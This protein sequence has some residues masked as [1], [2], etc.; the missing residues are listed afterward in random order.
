MRT[1]IGFWIALFATLSATAALAAPYLAMFGSDAENRVYHFY[2]DESAGETNLVTFEFSPNDGTITTAEIFTTL[3]RRD[4][5]TLY[6]ADP[7]SVVAG[8]TNGY[9][10][11]YAMSDAGSGKWALT[12]PIRKCGSYDIR[13]RYKVS[14]D[15]NWRW[16]TG[17]NPVVNISDV[18]TR[19]MIVYEM[20]ANVVDATGDSYASRSTFASLTNTTKN[21]NIDYISSLGVNTIW[22]QPFHP[23]GAKSDC[24]SGD[25]GSPYSIK[26]LFQVAEHLGSDGT[27]ATA[28][29]EFTNFVIAAHAKGVKVICDVIFNHVATDIEIE[30]DPDNPASLYST[31]SAEMRNVKYAWFSR[32]TGS[33]SDCAT[34]KPES[35][36]ANYHYTEPANNSS[37]IGPAP[38]DRNDFVWPDAYDLFWGTYSA[39]GNI[40]DTSDGAWTASTDV[41]KMTEYY[42]YFIRY[43]IEKTGGTMG[44]FRCDFA[45]GLPRQAWQYLINKAKSI[46]PE[47]YFVSESLDGGNIAYRA[48]KGGFDALNENELWAIVEDTDITTT[49]LRNII[50][51]R[52]TQFGL[53]LILRGTMNHDQGPWLGRKWDAVAMHSVFCAVDGTPQMYE[54]QELGYDALGQFSRERV[55]FGRTIPDIR[56]YHSMNNLWNNRSSGDNPALWHRYKD[57]NLGRSRATALR[58][59]NQYYLDRTGGQGPHSKIFSVMKYT[60]YGWDPKDQDVVLAFVNLQPGTANSGTFNVNVAPIYLNPT[61]TYNVRN[62]ASTSPG[63]YLWAQGR[64]GSDIAANGIYVGFSADKGQEGSIAQFLKLEEQGGSTPTNLAW[65]GNTYH[66]PTNGAITAADDLWVNI[67]SYP[68]GAASGGSVAYSVDNVTWLSATLS[69]DGKTASN[70]KWHANLGKFAAGAVVRYAVQ[71]VQQGGTNFWDNRGGS[72]Y[73][74]TVN[75]GGNGQRLQWIGVVSHWPT[76]GA[77]TASDDFW[78]DIQAWPTGAAANGFVVYSSDN[79]ATWPTR[80]LSL[81]NTSPSNDFWHA[82]LGKFAPGAT[83]QFAVSLSDRTGTNQLW[84]NNAGSNY[85]AYVNGVSTSGPSVYWA[86]NTISRGITRPD[87]S[88]LATLSGAMDL[89]VGSA[90]VGSTYELYRSTNLSSWVLVTNIVATGSDIAL[91]NQPVVEERVF[92]RI[93]GFVPY[94]ASV[95]EGDE[96]IIRAESWPAG[97]AVA[98]NIVYSSNGQNWLGTNMTKVG[99]SLNNDVWEVNLGYFPKGISIQYAIEIVDDQGFSRWDNNNSQNHSVAIRDPDQP[100]VT[101]P[102]LSY[103]PSNTTTAASSLDVTLTATDDFDAHPW[104][105]YTLDGSTPVWGSTLYSVPIHVTNNLTIKAIAFDQSGNTSGVVSVDVKVNEVVVMGSFKPYSVNPTFGHAVANGGITIDGSP[106]DWTTNMLVAL[107]VADDDPRTLGSNWTTHEAPIDFAYLW[108]AWDDNY[109]YLAW[110]YV[111]LTDLIDTA[112]AGSAGGGKISSNDGILQWIAID[113]IQGAGAAKDVWSKNGG[114]PYWAGADLPDYQVYMAGSLWQGYISRAVNGVFALD[115]GGVNYKTAAAAGISYA[116]GNTLGSGTLWMPSAN[117]ANGRYGTLSAVTHDTTRDSFYE[118]RIPLSFLQITR[119]QIEQNGIGVMMGAGS[120]SCMD[121]IPHD[122]TTLDAQGVE[123]WNSSKEWTDVD[124]FTNSFARIGHS[125]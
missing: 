98:A 99:A 91:T 34:T 41:K 47:L 59:A 2:I 30:R 48:W 83:I 92:Y 19:D 52:K 124:H 88:G 25:P 68:Q 24:N 115:D 35:D 5:A 66:W 42:A 93:G 44:G 20:Q 61:R 53:A 111:D 12:L 113:T 85:W 104:I 73:T 74:A 16:Y 100:D 90:R 108:A 45:Q 22:L 112:N 102:S 10:G 3:N 71:V 105:T 4:Q 58:V 89:H 72:N 78:V 81:N 121:S 1:R 117:N 27:R 38:A 63:T 21:W 69:S 15:S 116:K 6:P 55:E 40:N 122:E 43:W 95:F 28:M 96:L 86:G 80:D 84:A 118:I 125:K 51:Q 37:E 109:L 114:Q 7:N 54:G 50:D 70:D 56:N 76:N 49:D 26:N 57:A 46:K 101:A 29:R 13:A 39:L 14:G 79:G 97:R 110:Q 119:T 9:W 11:A 8:D 36:W 17:R 75:N 87:L 106:S 107:D 31:P 103:S 65:V 33:H 82:N 60:Q 32:Y 123:V 64:S 62:L 77:I 23:I 94:E 67:E 18:E 120:T